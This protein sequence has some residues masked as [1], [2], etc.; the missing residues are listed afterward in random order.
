LNSNLS[1]QRAIFA[2]LGGA[3]AAAALSPRVMAADTASSASVGLE[4]VVVTATR[5]TENLQD[6]PITIQATTGAELQQLNVSTINELLKYTPNVTFASN[7]PGMGNLYMRGLSYGGAPN[8]SQATI[9]PMPN[10]ALYLDDQSMQFPGRNA[11]VY[12]VDMERVEVLEGP[13]GTLFGGGAQAGALRYITNKPKLDSTHGEVNASYGTTSG[14]EPNSAVNGTLNLPLIEGKLAVRGTFY[15]DSRGGYID[16]E[17]G[18]IQVPAVL[19]A[20]QN[21]AGKPPL[22]A[23]GPISANAGM[24]ASNTNPVTYAGGRVGLLYKVND[25]WDFLL[26]DNFQ[27]FEADG[28]FNSEPISPNGKALAPYQLAAFAPAWDKDQ[29]N[30]IAWTVD[31]KFPGLL[32]SAGDLNLVYT[33]SY[34]DRNMDQQN[35]YSNY[36]TSRHGSYYACSGQGAGYAY[37]RS[38]KATTCYN[39][40]GTWRDIVDHTHQSHELRL[41][42]SADNRLRALV[43][44]FYENN[45]IKDNMNF[46]Y[47]PIPQCDATNL[48][49]SQAGGPD[50]VAAVGPIPNFYARDPGLRL[51]THT[52]FGE[53]VRRGFKQTAFFASVD[54]DIIPHVLTITGGTRH[55][56]YDEFE[57]GSEY[58]SATS[59]ILN[60]PNGTGTL[61]PK[62][63]AG[64]GINLSKSESGFKS[65]GNLTWHITPDVLVYYTYSQGFRPGGFNRTKTL[66]N[67]TVVLKAVAPYNADGSQKQFDKPVG[68]DSDDLTNNEVGLKSE[69]FEHRMQVNLSGYIM[70]WKN[71]Q[72]VLFDPVHLG[73][74]TFVVNGPTYRVKGIEAQI[75]AR[76]TPQLTLE[77]SGVWNSSNQ[78]DAPCLQANVAT[79]NGAAVGSCITQVNGLPY[80]NPYGVLNTT[81][82]FS[83]PQQ[84]NARFNFDF[85]AGPYKCFVSGGMSFM[86][87]M[88]NQ[89]ASYPD[90]NDPAYNPPTTTLL[91]YTMPSYTTYDASIG[92][93][94]DQWTLMLTGNNLSNENASTHTQSGQF[95]KTEIPLRPRVVTMTF[96][97]KF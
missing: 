92:M 72:L 84:Y 44:A 78:T 4:E 17:V 28:Y 63:Y 18:T 82:A 25:N 20:N 97:Y 6:V 76:V 73:N 55:Y 24:A 13:Q 66:L 21:S 29:Y 16:N 81:P 74:T 9:A 15:S 59:S 64:F 75:V 22:R 36:L 61:G 30:T 53:D 94:K 11:D 83:P 12:F 47:L 10:V 14:G 8:Q 85:N 79:A 86:G 42:T 32:G 80:T 62:P 2:I 26:Q 50:C 52:A 3:G 48:A 60:V 51:G 37:F 40:V 87:A 34:L 5:R 70:D 95:I 39:A 58:Y 19:P 35:D 54:F 46:N 45:V 41:S 67:G 91:K 69:W 38:T 90:G 49:I 65:R 43:G 71:A 93:G 33:G 77:G 88:R 96:G 31:G 27:H 89:P 57:Q 56:H 1:I 23:A 68:Y 7:G